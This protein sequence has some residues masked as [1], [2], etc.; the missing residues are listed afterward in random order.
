MFRY[1]IPILSFFIFLSQATVAEDRY[2]H[3][4]DSNDGFLQFQLEQELKRLGLSSAAQRGELSLVLVDITDPLQPKMASINGESM[5]Y[6]ASL[7][8]VAILL[9]V[10]ASIESGRMELNDEVRDKLVD[11]IRF[12]SNSAATEMLNRVGKEYLADILQSPRFAL[13]DEEYGGGLW[14]GKDYSKAP[15]WRRDPLHNFSHG[16]NALQ[17]ARLYYMLETGQLFSPE[18]SHEMKDILG[19]PGINHKFVK[20]LNEHRPGANI[21]RKSG[22]WRTWHSDSAIIERDGRR[23]IAVALANSPRGGIWLQKIIVAMDDIVCQNT[24]VQVALLD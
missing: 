3:L 7:P 20:G 17:V 1:F 24:P 22:S 13:Y 21:Y 9:G 4:I 12:S 5:M 11:M 2:P 23:Y 8:K 15:A 10:F 19:N 6:A 16:A 14:V 18:L